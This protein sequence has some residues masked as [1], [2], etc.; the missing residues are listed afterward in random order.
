MATVDGRPVGLLNLIVVGARTVELSLLV[1]DGW[2]RRGVATRLLATELDKPRWAGWT[3]QATVQPDNLPVRSLLRSGRFGTWELVDRDLSS[4]DFALALPPRPVPPS[5]E[6]LADERRR[7]SAAATNSPTAPSITANARLS[8]VPDSLQATRFATRLAT[9]AVSVKG[10]M[11]I[12]SRCR[13]AV[14]DSTDD[15][16]LITM[17][18]RDVPTARDIGMPQDDHQRGHDEEPAADAEEAG[19]EAGDHA[20]DDDLDGRA[21]TVAWRVA[22]AVPAPPSGSGRVVRT[23]VAAPQHRGGGEQREAGEGDQQHRLVDMAVDQGAE[24]GGGDADGAERDAGPPLDTAFPD[25]DEG[26]DERG[27][28]DDE[29]PARGGV[30]RVL[31]QHVDQ[32]GHGE[33]ATPAAEAADDGADH[34]PERRGDEGRGGHSERAPF[35]PGQHRPNL[36]DDSPNVRSLRRRPATECQ[37]GT[38][39]ALAAR[40]AAAMRA[41][42]CAIRERRRAAGRGGRVGHRVLGSKWAGHQHATTRGRYVVRRQRRSSTERRSIAIRQIQNLRPASVDP[43]GIRTVHHRSARRSTPRRV[44]HC[45]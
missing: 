36:Q 33:H 37:K 42:S 39:P 6:P 34:D 2:Q 38:F 32:R 28:A 10:P 41:M 8:V 15:A 44:V 16:A 3:V 22:T 4:W 31:A 20:A 45:E 35:R 9:M 5:P 23:L 29:H 7:C 21:V 13:S 40:T 18:N 12:Q 26:A 24:V 14:R 17:M 25:A 27:D 19:E 1:A 11:T 43:R 30:V